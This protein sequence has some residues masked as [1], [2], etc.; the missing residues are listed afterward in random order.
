VQAA[1]DHVDEAEDVARR[2]GGDRD[3]DYTQF[4]PTNV[5]LHRMDM[6]LR[7]EDGWAALEAA[8]DLDPEALAGLSRERQAGHR[9]TVAHASLLTRRKEDAAKALIEA[10]ALAP[11]EVRGRPDTVN[12]VKDVV[13]ATANPGAGLRALAERCGLRA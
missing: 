10:D 9:V 13:G 8:E 3:E 11:E 5:V 1:G 2:Q 4:G 7:F 6:L 12:L